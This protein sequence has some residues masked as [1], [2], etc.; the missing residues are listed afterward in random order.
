MSKMFSKITL[1]VLIVAS[2][3]ILTLD[4]RQTTMLPGTVKNFELP[5]FDDKSGVKEWELFGSQA[6]YINDS[7][8]DITDIKLDLY[9]GKVEAKHRAT[10]TSPTAQVNP[11]TKI[12][13]SDS[14]LFVNA[15]EFDMSGKKWKWY[16]DKR[17]VEVFS[18]VK[19][20]VKPRSKNDSVTNFESRYANLNYA[21]DSN[22]FELK[23]NVSVKNDEMNLNCEYLH[24]KSSKKKSRGV[25][26]IIAKGKVRMLKDKHLTYS[27]SA[28]I[29]PEKG[30]AIL[31]ESPKITDVP[32]KSELLGEKI[33]L[34]KENKKIETFSSNRQRATAII[35][36]TDD[37]KKEQKITILSDKIVMSQKDSQNTFDF[38][39]NVNIIAEDFTAKCE[40]LH[41]LSIAKEGEKPKLEYIR[42]FENIRFENDDGVATS[43]SMEII[44]Q[45]SEIWLADNVKLDNPKRGTTLSADAVVFFRAQNK[46]LAMSYPQKKDLFVVVTIKDSPTFEDATGEKKNEKKKITTVIKSKKLN[47]SKTE[48]T[49]D[50]VFTKDVTI[51][52]DDIN[53]TC[54]KMTVFAETD[55]NGSSTAKKI[56]ATEQVSVKQKGYSANAEIATIYPQLAKK[57]AG[58]KK[59]IHKFVELATDPQ[60]PLLR[61]TV[62]LPPL[63]NIGITDAETASDAK[64]QPTVIKSDK[65]WLT[66]AEKADRY[67]FQGNVQIDGTDMK[68]TCE[69]IEVVMR[70]N[71]PN[72]QKEIAQIIMTEN[73][74]LEQRLKEVHCGRADI[75]ANDQIVVLTDN[76]IVINRED[77]SRASGHKIIYNKGNQSIQ[78]ESDPDAIIPRSSTPQF[79]IPDIDDEND[80]PKNRPK[81]RLPI[82]R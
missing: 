23:G 29:D 53:A 51:V 32:S 6:E 78:V 68:S 39:G 73:V 16:G 14:D 70:P 72:G 24:A 26:D 56:V 66:S 42:G 55:E 57:N 65:Q 36:H 38:L 5:H 12:S 48:K 28:V 80:T 74:K 71:K 25:S 75:M 4:A 22:V 69:K 63:K 40:K 20:I 34:D 13:E 3:S 8:I 18:N 10:I 49:I 44:P 64:S 27:E 59:S 2:C 33:V 47:F 15:N 81:I 82:R 52:S 31:T 9:E 7:R 35:F 21:G 54:Q 46:G 43:K 62:T 41:A 37:S 19:I 76:P 67:Y 11:N 61:P 60:N 58:T 17:F 30:I 77:N 79:T 50:F 1:S 45:K